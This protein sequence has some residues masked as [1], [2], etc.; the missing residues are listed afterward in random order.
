MVIPDSVTEIGA[1]AFYN[2][3]QL[4]KLAFP[5]SVETI[6]SDAFSGSNQLKADRNSGFYGYSTSY[7]ETYAQ[8]KGIPFYSL[9]RYTGGNPY[10]P[11]ALEEISLSESSLKLSA[12]QSSELKVTYTPVKATSDHSIIWSSDDED[13]ATVDSR[14]KITAVAEGETVIN[15]VS[16]FKNSI[17]A[18]CALTVIPAPT[19]LKSVVVTPSSMPKMI[20][21]GKMD[22]TYSYKPENA[23]YP[24]V[25]WSSSDPSVVSVDQDGRISAVKEGTVTVSA[26]AEAGNNVKGTCRVTVMNGTMIN[27][28]AMEQTDLIVDKNSSGTVSISSD[29]AD[30][31]NTDCLWKSDDPAVAAVPGNAVKNCT[32]RGISPGETMIYGY[33]TDGSNL[34]VSRK[35]I[36]AEPVTGISLSAGSI[37]MNLGEAA[38]LKATVLPENAFDRSVTWSTT[39]SSVATVDEN[40]NVTAVGKG[41]CTIKA[42]TNRNNKTASCSVRVDVPVSSVTLNMNQ[43]TLIKGNSS[44]LSATV[45]PENANDKTVTW[46]SDRP[47]VATV[48]EGVLRLHQPFLGEPV[49]EE[50]LRLG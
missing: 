4:Y 19:E 25:I 45:L 33:T 41:T 26:A 50:K 36:I 1:Q 21:G 47:A 10:P 40:G 29:P 27:T 12:G 18:S 31:T 37:A 14:G 5:W 30:A 23:Q 38:V 39:N 15:A 20:V 9:D 24:R 35:V 6:A 44:R 7:A 46:S 48:S 8:E 32:V 13:I 34:R 2:C 42:V 28:A 49:R 16:A 22:L 3:S 17:T 43:L 11:L